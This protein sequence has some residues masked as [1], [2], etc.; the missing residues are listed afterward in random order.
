[1]KKRETC[2][3]GVLNGRKACPSTCKNFKCITLSQKIT[4]HRLRKLNKYL[5][6]LLL[7]NCSDIFIVNLL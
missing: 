6:S 3:M 2:L 7:K 4:S 5:K 1:M